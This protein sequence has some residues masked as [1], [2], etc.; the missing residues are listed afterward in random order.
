MRERGFTLVEMV[1]VIAIMVILM[2]MA[3][4]QFSRMTRKSQIESQVRTLYADLMNARSEALLQKVDRSVKWTGTQFLVYPNSSATDP[5][6]RQTTLKYGVTT[7]IDFVSFDSRGVASLSSPP[8]AVCVEPAGNPAA[9]DS[10][11][12]DRT[13][14]QMGKW[15]GGAC[16]SANITRK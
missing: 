6:L 9:V 8:M 11:I 4:M 14:I 10:I 2:A 7:D 12:I 16:S 1:V 5:P 13:M 3:T 15:N